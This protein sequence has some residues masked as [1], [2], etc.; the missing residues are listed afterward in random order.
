MVY[1]SQCRKVAIVSV[2]GTPLCVSCFLEFQ[3]A[4]QM[5]DNRLVNQ[6]NFL[7]DMA[8]TTAGVSGVLPRFEVPQTMVHTGPIKFNNINIDRS[9]VGLINTGEVQQIDVSVSHIKT[10]GNEELAK[11]LTEFTEAVTAE[12]SLD[13]NLKNQLIEQ[14][15]FLA[16]QLTQPKEKRKSGLVKAVL[17]GV[18]ETICT[19]SSLLTIWGKLQ[20]LL[21]KVFS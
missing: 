11:A 21:D 3:Q 19:I 8:E 17:I 15:S 12:H 6:M 13:I 16:S 10:S 9:V 20:P 5:Q 2:N 7:L 1:C 14:I 18:K 4:I